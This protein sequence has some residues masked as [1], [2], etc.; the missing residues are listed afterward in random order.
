MTAHLT[1]SRIGHREM[2]DI[3]ITGKT[4]VMTFDGKD[5]AAKENLHYDPRQDPEHMSDVEMMFA[6]LHQ[7]VQTAKTGGSPAMQSEYEL[8]IIRDMIVCRRLQD[9]LLYRY[10]GG[11]KMPSDDAELG[12]AQPFYYEPI[13]IP[14]YAIAG[15]QAAQEQYVKNVARE[16]SSESLTPP[17]SRIGS[18]PQVAKWRIIPSR[19]WHLFFPCHVTSLMQGPL[20]PP[21]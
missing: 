17:L 6:K 12:D 20:M 9:L 10:D 21:Y 16:S 13:K 8:R 11:Y 1:V 4:G 5:V 3:V 19:D 7:Q 18:K 15:G 2:E 14:V